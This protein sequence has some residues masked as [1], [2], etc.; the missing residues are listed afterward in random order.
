MYVA[1]PRMLEMPEYNQLESRLVARILTKLQGNL[2][3]SLNQS[4]KKPQHRI[5]VNSACTCSQDHVT[6]VSISEI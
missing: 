6:T 4:E 2:R 1:R 5:L 3:K